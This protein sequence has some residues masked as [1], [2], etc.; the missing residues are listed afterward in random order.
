MESKSSSSTK[1]IV[2]G[3]A[4]VLACCLCLALAAAAGALLSANILRTTDQNPSAT[5]PPPS[6]AAATPDIA[7]PV[8][9][10][11]KT[12][13]GELAQAEVP[14][15]DPIALAEQFYGLTDIPQVEA[16]T[17]TPIATGT[18]ETFWASN[19]DD[20]TNFQIKAE[21]AYASDHIY[22]WVEQGVQ[23]DLGDVQRL[24]DEF[25]RKAY[26]TDREFFGSEWTPGVDGD[27]H[28]YILYARNLGSSVAGYYSSNDEFVP[29]VHKY[30]NAH[31]MF[32]LSADNLPTLQ[33]AFTSGVLAH[34]FQHMI[35]W[36]RDRNEETWMNEG[37]SELAAYI[38]GYDV[39]GFD[40]SYALDPDIPLTYWPSEPGM[41]GAHYGQAFMF[42]KYFL[43]R[44]GADATKAVVADPANG[45]DS[46]DQVLAQLNQIDAVSGAPITADDVFR[47]WAAAMVVQDPSVAGGLYAFKNYPG[48]PQISPEE[49]YS[50]CSGPLQMRDVN[51]YGINYIQLDCQGDYTLDFRGSQLAKVVPADPHG[52]EFDF[53][54]NRGDESTMTLTRTFD[55][56]QVQG[57][58]DLS[59]WTWYDIEA[60][61]DYLYLEA[62]ADG[63]Q[64][65]T[66]VHTPSGT[67]ENPSGNSYGWAYNGESGG[68]SSAQWINESVDLSAYAG[69][70]VDLRFEYITDAA[71]NGE[72][73][74]LDDVAI[75][76]IDYQEGFENGDGGW[77]AAGF[78]RLFNSLPQTYRVLLVQ[79]GAQDPVQEVALNGE[80]Q[81]SLAVYLLGGRQKAYLVVM[82]TTRHT[83]QPA[84]YWF[85]FTP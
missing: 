1:W 2:G 13:A 35:H 67:A 50:D 63:G 60:G 79:P 62:S 28:L 29:E 69:Q 78:V 16:T 70:K 51:Q 34:E 32:Y 18:V 8:P 77:Q 49:T 59:Y 83:W 73:F 15:V 30:S 71:V 82:A 6:T 31:E 40:A 47:D 74:L 10:E 5:M 68:G 61:Y 64:T 23:Y 46:I 33:G 66:I 53:W 48:E 76:A 45:L 20:N 9:P 4:L 56:S 38:N 81:G 44:F 84:D 85:Q 37:F 57:P 26:P 7:T 14:V 72:G 80:S 21:L 54:S 75:P 52:G 43:D 17:S 3:V 24:V 55:F 12:M 22:F 65:W 27:P 42:L 39:G 19:V 11:A 41:A 58:I 25:E 36:Y